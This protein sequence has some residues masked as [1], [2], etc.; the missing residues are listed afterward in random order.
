[1]RPMF[2]AGVLALTLS[3]AALAQTPPPPAAPA[4]APP[5]LTAEQWRADLRSMA[6]QMEGRHKNLF[7]S[8]TREQFA[9]A[10][11]DLDRRIP[12]LQRHQIIVGMMR[13]AAMVGDGHTN[14]SPLKDAAF[15]FRSL[16]LKF[17]L[18]DDGLFVRAAEP[19]HAALVGARVEAIG[20]VPVETALRRAAEISPRDNAI[21]PK[22]Y[23]PIFLAMP[24][25]LHA[26]GLAPTPDAA[27]L[28]LS[29][30][31][32]RWTVAVPAGGVEPG[33]PPDTDVS[34]VTPPGWT[35]ARRAPEPPLWLQAPLDYHR[36]VELPGALY[37]Q[38]N[39]VA[40][41]KGETVAQF[42]ARIRARAEAN[43]PKAV[44][45]DL[46]LNRG[47]N[48]DLRYGFVRELVRTEDADTRLFVLSAR[49]TFSATQF[50]LDDL[51]RY[52]D[53]VLL[54]EPA[55]SKPNSYGDSYRNLL[56]NSG[57]T[58]R[59]SIRWHQIGSREQPWTYLDL[60][61][62]Y[63]FADYAAGRDPV[64]QAALAYTPSPSLEETALAAAQ[65]GGPEAV[66]RAFEAHL[67]APPNR[68][69]DHERAVFRAA[70]RLH[71]EKHAPEAVALM[72][73]AERAYPESA[74]V[75]LVLAQMA[76]AAGE[77]ALARRAAARSLQ[78]DPDSRPART[79][80][81]RLGPP[82]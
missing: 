65:A 67:A 18:F 15:Q 74:D 79:L 35:D 48:G 71:R 37:A 11:A 43:N 30:D 21:G 26:L 1:M 25:I 14:V 34:L 72:Q 47:G 59:T 9:A 2:A 57:L 12:S 53:A 28:T 6:E 3:Q 23:Q 76:E 4:A 27:V 69:A 66:R 16:P 70:D 62:P 31:G 68:W 13:I 55:S 45:V 81:E 40:D 52:T 38:L 41:V 5:A 36:L 10:V 42:G 54:G 29:R 50:I 63:R 8:V 73:A 39:M 33:W 77:T 64:L 19:G 20:G 58:V 60:A 17:Y 78:L 24:P 80:A 75:A 44:I 22:L 61:V 7:H 56:P 49:G 82:G 46:R 32:R 51:D